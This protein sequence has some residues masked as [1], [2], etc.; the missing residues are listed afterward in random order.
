MMT[1]GFPCRRRYPPVFF[2]AMLRQSD[3]H[4]DNGCCWP[5]FLP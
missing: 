3:S 2:V 1:K 5:S 4:A